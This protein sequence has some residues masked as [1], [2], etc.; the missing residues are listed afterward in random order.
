[1]V[2]VCEWDESAPVFRHQELFSIIFVLH[3]LNQQ[4]QLAVGD[5]IKEIAAV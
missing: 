2:Q 3:R 1:M 5:I 4:L